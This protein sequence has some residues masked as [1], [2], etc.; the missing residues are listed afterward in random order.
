MHTHI[1][2]YAFIYMDRLGDTIDWDRQRQTGR[3]TQREGY[4]TGR[5]GHVIAE[6]R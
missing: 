4:R 2:I 6:E 3:V 1:Q 5:V